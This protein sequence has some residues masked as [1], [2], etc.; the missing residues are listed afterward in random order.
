MIKKNEYLSTC[1]SIMPIFSPSPLSVGEEKTADRDLAAIRMDY[2][3]VS[4]RFGAGTISPEL[5]VED[6]TS[7]EGVLDMTGVERCAVDA[8]V[9]AVEAPADDPAVEE[10][11]DGVMPDEQAVGVDGEEEGQTVEAEFEDYVN[12]QPMVDVV[13]YETTVADEGSAAAQASHDDRS[14]VGAGPMV[15]EAVVETVNK[16]PV[17]TVEDES[18]P[19]ALASEFEGTIGGLAS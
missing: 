8:A 1:P 16:T 6:K 5:A 17:G 4:S 11:T 10:P 7:A 12:V 2:S 18:S 14:L 13:S 3:A 15:I 19:D 9:A